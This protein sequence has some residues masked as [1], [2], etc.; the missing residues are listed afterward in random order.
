MWIQILTNAILEIC[1][2]SDFMIIKNRV[3]IEKFKKVPNFPISLNAE[4]IKNDIKNTLEV[5]NFNTQ[6]VF[7][8]NTF[9]YK[10]KISTKPQNT[11][12]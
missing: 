10:P 4:I 5:K 7:I 6:L 11:D 1:P 3:K 8:C 9:N 2:G 12:F